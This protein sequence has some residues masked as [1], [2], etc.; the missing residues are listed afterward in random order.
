MLVVWST[1]RHYTR[2]QRISTTIPMFAS[3][4]T[5]FVA[6][7]FLVATVQ[8]QF[9]WNAYIASVTAQPPVSGSEGMVL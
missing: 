9:D 6:L 5:A 8:A 7:A 2:R 4:G 3:L 1:S